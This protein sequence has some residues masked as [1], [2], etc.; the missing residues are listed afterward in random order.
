MQQN[1]S[2]RANPVNLLIVCMIPPQ[3]SYPYGNDDNN[4]LPK[5]Y[6]ETTVQGRVLY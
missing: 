3:D 1:P 2:Y 4:I 5:L 6:E